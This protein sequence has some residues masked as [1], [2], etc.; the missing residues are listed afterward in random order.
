MHRRDVR[1]GLHRRFQP[2][3]EDFRQRPNLSQVLTYMPQVK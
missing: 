3:Q 2:Q 1:H